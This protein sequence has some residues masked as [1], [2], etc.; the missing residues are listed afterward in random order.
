MKRVLHICNVPRI[1][2]HRLIGGHHTPGHRMAVGLVIMIGGVAVA[3]SAHAAE[4]VIIQGGLDLL[5]YAIHGLGA[6]PFI[7]WLLEEEKDREEE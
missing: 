2:C 7:E 3:K 5:G 1:I 6:V 4:Y